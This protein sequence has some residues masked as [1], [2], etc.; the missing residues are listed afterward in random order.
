MLCD[1]YIV[2]IIIF[3]YLIC[4]INVLEFKKNNKKTLLHHLLPILV[5]KVLHQADYYP[6][7]QKD[8][9]VLSLQSFNHPKNL[10]GANCDVKVRKARLSK[11]E[12]K[13]EKIPT[14]SLL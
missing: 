3:P 10:F 12:S 14:A 11:D 5:K 4:N 13:A 1:D 7:L 8:L 2:S 9:K 6:V